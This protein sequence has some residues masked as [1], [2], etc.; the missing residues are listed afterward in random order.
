VS[1]KDMLVIGL[2][3]PLRGDDG[4]GIWIAEQIAAADWPDV[5][6]LAI[7]SGEPTQLIEAW[8]G[9]K[10]VYV[11]DALVAPLPP[12]RVLRFD[13]LR[14]PVPAHLATFSTHGLGLSEAVQ[15]ARILGALPSKLTLY[16]IVGQQFAYGVSLTPEVATA[17]QYVVARLRR[18]LRH[19]ATPGQH[20][21]PQ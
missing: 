21:S 9:A 19:A 13:L 4:V 20:R 3:N 1:N 5:M 15:L 14:N 10:R 7:E 17:A 8:A 16:G 11:V 2:G 6:V 18:L 12:G